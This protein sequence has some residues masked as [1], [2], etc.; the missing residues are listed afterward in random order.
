MKT[1]DKFMAIMKEGKPVTYA[2]LVYKL[3]V[4]KSNV[5]AYMSRARKKHEIEEHMDGNMKVFTYICDSNDK[6]NTLA[7][8]ELRKKAEHLLKAL[9]TIDH[10]ILKDAF[11]I[12]NSE[13]LCLIGYLLDTNKALISANWNIEAV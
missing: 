6:L 2:D 12:N 4:P 11:G 13:A 8:T 3:G 5:S 1:M 10:F 9:G 7:Q